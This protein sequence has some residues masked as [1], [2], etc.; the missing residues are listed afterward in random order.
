MILQFQQC[1]II[2]IIELGKKCG[3]P[4]PLFRMNKKLKKKIIKHLNYKVMIYITLPLL[5]ISG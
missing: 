3:F 5:V 1:K 4:L 2:I